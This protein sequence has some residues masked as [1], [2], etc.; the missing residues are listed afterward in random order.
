MQEWLRA[1][2][3]LSEY[4]KPKP[5]TLSIIQLWGNPLKN[6]NLIR[7]LT[8]LTLLSGAAGAQDFH[9]WRRDGV[10]IITSVHE[11]YPREAILRKVNEEVFA[12][13]WLD[14]TDDGEWIIPYVQ[15]FR[16]SDAGVGEFTPAI[17]AVL[18][19]SANACKLRMDITRFGDVALVWEN[20]RQDSTAFVLAQLI[21]IE[22][23]R[24][25]SDSGIWCSTREGNQTDPLIACDDAGNTF[26]VWSSASD[27]GDG[28]LCAQ[29]L[30][31]HG[32]RNW[33]AEGIQITENLFI[34]GEMAVQEYPEDLIIN[35]SGR[36][37]FV[38][39]RFNRHDRRMERDLYITKILP[40]GTL[41]WDE[42]ALTTDRNDQ[43]DAKI[44]ECS[45]NYA[46][47]WVDDRDD[48]LGS[49][50]KDIFG[51][52]LNR[53]GENMWRDS[54]FFLCGNDQ[55][56]WKP[57]ITIDNEG[58][59]WTVWEDDRHISD[60]RFRNHGKSI[61]I[62]KQST[63]I[64]RRRRPLLLLREDDGDLAYDGLPVCNETD[65]QMNP[66][67]LHDG[68]N[69]IWV[70]WQDSRN[71]EHFDIYATHLQTDADPFEEWDDNG[72]S[73]CD[74]GYDQRNPQMILRGN[75]RDSQI[76]VIWEDDRNCE[77]EGHSDIYCHR[78]T[79]HRALDYKD[80]NRS[81]LSKN[82]T[83][84]TI[85]PNPFNS[86]AKITYTIPKPGF[87]HFRL[88]DA[89]G[90]LVENFPNRWGTAGRHSF[91]LDGKSLDSGFY[92]LQVQAGMQQ[93]S[94]KVLLVK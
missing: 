9:E 28:N 63:E 84:E 39:S 26:I 58:N 15:L 21:Y 75:G 60:R 81:P 1:K 91:T 90:R 65:D 37:V 14:L 22:G 48:E 88:F 18:N 68:E 66:Q 45:N 80:A 86:T 77:T 41:E 55:H 53:F 54:G 20:R 32:N 46:V 12:V 6:D 34:R 25:W 36:L 10:Q 69:G 3:I 93:R 59:I 29:F 51:Q 52:F 82:I 92:V 16:D 43:I 76:L 70:I 64:D 31:Y 72:N 67:M 62:Q 8:F 73:I 56:Q 5:E 24:R 79:N 47:A 17:P 40:N 19:D 33:G 49:P 4:D 2:R 89:G 7:L 87:V 57:Q 35:R 71:F 42:I 78:I 85:A 13:A 23:V 50:Q 30:D 27:R 74:A 11:G 94:R 38:W 61:Y 83:L 44:I